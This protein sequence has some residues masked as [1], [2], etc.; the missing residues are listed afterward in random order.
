MTT[1]ILLQVLPFAEAKEG[2]VGS[3]HRPI[4]SFTMQGFGLAGYLKVYLSAFCGQ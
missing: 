4:K 3:N 1:S 2:R